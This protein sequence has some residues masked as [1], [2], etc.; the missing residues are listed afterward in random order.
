MKF[1]SK[2]FLIFSF[3]SSSFA[4]VQDSDGLEEVTDTKTRAKPPISTFSS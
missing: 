4:F 1:S 2:L 3:L